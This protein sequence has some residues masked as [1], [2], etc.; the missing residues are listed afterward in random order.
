MIHGGVSQ[1]LW[2]HH[3][4]CYDSQAS[5]SVMSHAKNAHNDKIN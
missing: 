2:R 5:S 3:S 4:S 1:V